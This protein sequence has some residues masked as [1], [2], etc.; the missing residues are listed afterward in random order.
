M[1]TTKVLIDNWPNTPWFKEWIPIIIALIAL[2]TAAISLYWTRVEQIKSSRPF[3][4]ATNYGVI[5]NVNKTIIP[6]PFRIGCRVKNSPARILLMEV[7]I[8]LETNELFAHTDKNLVQFPDE[9]SEW[10]F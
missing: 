2:I 6:I 10:S 4:W 1:E 5:D 8:N 7:K 9:S 3:V